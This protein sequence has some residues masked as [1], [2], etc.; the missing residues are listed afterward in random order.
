MPPKDEPQPPPA[1]SSTL[2]EW[3]NAALD[4]AARANA[5]DPA[6]SCCDGSP[7]PNTPTRCA[8]LTGVGSLSTP[9]KSFPW[10]PLRARAS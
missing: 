7:T 1:E 3:V 4:E 2:I 8:T 10:I 9:R 5:G 6:R